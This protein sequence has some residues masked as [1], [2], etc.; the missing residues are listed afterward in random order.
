MG[1]NRKINYYRVFFIA[2]IVSLIFGLPHIL[3]KNKLTAENKV[4]TPLVS[5]YEIAN[6][7]SALTDD[8]THLYA[9][10]VR[11]VLDGHFVITDAHSLEYKRRPYYMP[12]F[13]E[14]CV[15]LMSY[16]TG[17]VGNSFILADFLF[18]AL[19]F[20]LVFCLVYMIT[21]NECLSVLGGVSTIIIPRVVNY[22]V[23][24]EIVASIKYLLLQG[25]PSLLL[26]SRLPNPQLSFVLVML[27][28]LSLYVGLVRKR[29]LYSI[30]SGVLLGLCFYTYI[31]FWTFILAGMFV[32]T[33][34]FLLR[35][36]VDYVKQIILSGLIGFVTSIPFWLNFMAF[37]ALP[38]SQDILA[39]SSVEYGRTLTILSFP[40]LLF[41]FCYY[42]L[43]KKR[44]V[45]FYFIWSFII[46]G[47]LCRNLQLVT[48]YT[49]QSEHWSY[50]VLDPW[51][52]ISLAVL[53]ADI[54]QNRFK[55]VRLV[56]LSRGVCVLLIVLILSFGF[57]SQKGFADLR[58]PHY[59]LDSSMMDS[60][61]W[62][63]DNTQRDSVVLSD[64][65]TAALI[66]VYTHNNV[67]TP[68]ALVTL[69][70]TGEM[71]ERMMIA[72]KVFNA[73]QEYFRNYVNT[74][75]VYYY[76]NHLEN[77]TYI[78][79]PT[80]I[81][82]LK[83]VKGKRGWRPMFSE[84]TQNRLNER[85][86]DYVL[87]ITDVVGRYRVDYVYCGI[88]EKK[89]GDVNLDECDWLKEAYSNGNVTIYQI[90]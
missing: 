38:Y 10:R 12:F 85:Y 69:M 71:E 88:C 40:Y 63:D 54:I 76:I 4:Y 80:A 43:Y 26:F 42:L 78:T 18:P 32:L 3:I 52:L 50:N 11:E 47:I 31:Y 37:R 35:H 20:L 19:I 7:V 23:R 61:N 9:P 44:N 67:F 51:I 75:R 62:L 60:F 29:I 83:Q 58:Y 28:V 41:A 30:I 46:G 8:E 56:G 70:P 21:K 24:F 66:P 22:F 13:S 53:W 72:L 34:I 16:L 65:E 59:T 39:K 82:D 17:S 1:E 48:G 15:G 6:Q 25:E 64:Y 68:Y 55:G 73:S 89:M 81:F 33:V 86:G 5:S 87:N 27:I 79:P 2:I 84:E 90:V 36:E 57:F 49:V 74:T 14:L 77:V 45:S